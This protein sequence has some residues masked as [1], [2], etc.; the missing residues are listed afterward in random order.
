MNEVTMARPAETIIYFAEPLF[1]LLI[2][3]GMIFPCPFKLK[4]QVDIQSQAAGA[5]VQMEL[6]FC[7]KRPSVR[8]CL[9]H[10]IESVPSVSAESLEY[11]GDERYHSCPI[12]CCPAVPILSDAI[13]MFR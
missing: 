9:H 3:P 2:K 12:S 5:D 13:I 1:E 8:R 10:L 6:A 7:I 4:V 11:S